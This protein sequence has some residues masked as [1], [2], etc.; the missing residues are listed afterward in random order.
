MGTILFVSLF[1]FYRSL[2]KINLEFNIHKGNLVLNILAFGLPII[3]G[4]SYGIFLL[5]D[6]HEVSIFASVEQTSLQKNVLIASFIYE[7]VMSIVQLL[8]LLII[9]NYSVKASGRNS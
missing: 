8:Q 3:A 9:T 5:I 1:R 7:L 6:D 2:R 4:F